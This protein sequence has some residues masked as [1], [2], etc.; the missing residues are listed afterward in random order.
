M[1][2]HYLAKWRLELPPELRRYRR[3]EANNY[4]TP[5]RLPSTRRMTWLLLDKVKECKEEEQTLLKKIEKDYPEI[6]SVKQLANR[7]FKLINGRMIE[8]LDGWI[9]EASKSSSPEM[10]AFAQG[11]LRDK[12]AV[13]AALKYKW[14]QGQVEGQV[15]KLK[16]IKR[17][18]YGRAKFDLL[19]A[20]VLHAA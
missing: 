18:M 6:A 14:S 4:P 8:D 13:E 2:R 1:L 20:R 16:T 10:Q 17:G 5:I 12:A 11:I 3:N 19:K 15:N 7:F 9:E